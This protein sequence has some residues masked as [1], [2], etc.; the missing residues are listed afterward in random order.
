MLLQMVIWRS[1]AGQDTERDDK[2][3]VGDKEAG[4]HNV[5]EDGDME[6]R[7]AG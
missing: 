6:E 7:Y 5:A 3:G 2:A 1:N 4:A